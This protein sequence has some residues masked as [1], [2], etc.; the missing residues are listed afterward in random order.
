[1]DLKDRIVQLRARRG[2]TQRDLAHRAGLALSS[3]ARFEG[4]GRPRPS[5][6]RKL[7]AALDVAVEVLAAGEV[8][9]APRV[10]TPR[11][12]TFFN[13]DQ[14]G[15]PVLNQS[16]LVRWDWYSLDALRDLTRTFIPMPP[17]AEGH[18]VFISET[19]ETR[20]GEGVPPGALVVVYPR[21]QP[22]SGN[23][24]VVRQGTFVAVRVY[25]LEP[26]PTLLS[27]GGRQR[28]VVWAE[29]T[30]MLYIAGVWVITNRP[31]A[32]VDPQFL[33]TTVTG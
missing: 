12:L 9:E 32:G 11:G 17:M 19:V 2:F 20:V 21:L 3:I 26:D 16:A 18:F 27:T 14:S 28:P 24:V 5:T 7:A 29:E 10:E 23:L 13:D 6:M 25:S 30:K 31:T 15:L 1:M 33:N 22:V 4:G 8:E